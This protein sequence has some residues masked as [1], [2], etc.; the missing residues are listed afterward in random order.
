[1]IVLIADKFESKGVDELRAAGC[2]VIHDPALSGDALR[3]AI[4]QTN[5]DV[6][7][8][9]STEVA[10]PML[11]ASPT[12]AVVVRAG[13]GVNT[14][15][16]AAAS[17]R[18]VLVANCP[19]KNAVAVAELTFGLILSLDR[20]I[21]DNVAD[22]RRGQWNKAQYAQ[23]RGLKGRTLGLIGMGRIG[24]AVVKRAQAFEMKVV[25]WSRSLTKRQA[26]DWG[27]VRCDQPSEV[28][29]RCDILSIHLAACAATKNLIDAKVL[30]KLKSGS[31]FINTARAEVVDYDALKKVVNEK[32]IRVGLDV[33]PEEP[34]SG[35]G[36]FSSDLI[37]ADGI[38]YGTHHI[39]ASTEQ[40]QR[41]IAQETVN[42]VKEYKLSGQV[43]NC[44]NLA[45]E[46]RAKYIVVVRHRNRPG[47]LAHTLNVISYAGVN[48]EEMENL[49]CQ[50]GE[51]ACAFIK[52]DGPLGDQTMR[53]IKEGNQHIFAVSQ[54]A[55]VGTIV[56]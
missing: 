6:L 39:G 34:S 40:A 55:V 24:Q 32:G 23:A 41:A 43:R 27:V 28:A 20:R 22:L 2:E 16:V 12:L 42:I 14:I 1:M 17:R 4:A 13:A 52:L 37:G 8:V 49:I 7:V 19:G 10:E 5:C 46:S 26:G 53:D 21:A 35:A 31:Y 44:V 47:V 15:D 11:D 25:A 18:S 56:S 3:D 38:V 51:S 9:R 54:G 29:A 48:V 30:D 45:D 36:E 33:Y 50:G